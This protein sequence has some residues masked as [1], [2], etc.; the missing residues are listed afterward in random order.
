MIL[1]VVNLWA[2]RRLL[3]R[4]S[5]HP[6]GM[7]TIYTWAITSNPLLQI[8]HTFCMVSYLL[9]DDAYASYKALKEKKVH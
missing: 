5:A 4:Q 2:F 9:T 6:P 3:V 1:T 8:N 7:V